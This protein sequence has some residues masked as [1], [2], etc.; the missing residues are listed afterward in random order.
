M[1]LKDV[2]LIE[3]PKIEDPRGNLTFIEQTN[4]IPFEIKRVYYLYGIP[5]GASRGAHAHKKQHEFL[6]PI[7]CSFDVLVKD[8]DLES[9]YHLNQA[10]CG[11]YL[12]EMVWRDLCNFSMDSICLVLSSGPFDEGD[13]IREY[14]E[15]QK[16]IET[17]S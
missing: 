6:I 7:S 16:E 12:P 8:G 5:A 9:S 1:S 14:S 3:L 10:S 17:L 15:F 13:Y 11:L 4:H 2:R